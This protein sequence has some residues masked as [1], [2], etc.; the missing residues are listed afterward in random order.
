MAADGFTT[1]HVTTDPVEGEMLA[2]ALRGEAIE[3]RV[4]H[5]NSA[6]LGAGPQLF[7][8]R[9]LVADESAA[10]ARAI[11]E[12]LRYPALAEELSTA[13]E[14]EDEDG[15]PA[16]TA[17]NPRRVGIGL[18]VPGFGHFAARLPWTAL[19]LEV[20]IFCAIAGL[21]FRPE[22]DFVSNLAFATIFTIMAADV[23][24]AWRAL[25]SA[26]SGAPLSQGRQVARGAK[27]LGGALAGGAVAATLVALPGWVRGGG[28]ASLDVSCTDRAVTIS[29]PSHRA[30]YASLDYVGVATPVQTEAW[31][32]RVVVDDTS[33]V[34]LEA[35]EKIVRGLEPRGID[36]ERCRE[37]EG[38]QADECALFLRLT[39]QD[40][41]SSANEPLAVAGRCVPDWSGA[42]GASRAKL[43]LVEP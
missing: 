20:G 13:P 40:I 10:Q 15:A 3:A 22:R 37:S 25:R 32:S 42:H 39:V 35:G 12:D 26:A 41:D 27:L 16:P 24:G 4:E 11:L 9:V 33:V 6:L 23:V 19:T 1:V 30:R 7:E 5:V 36:R 28:L 43:E 31:A 34:R 2:E 17:R 14:P 21:R 29:N 18:L 8:I 38:R